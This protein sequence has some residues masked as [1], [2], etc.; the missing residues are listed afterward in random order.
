MW[1][2]GDFN[3]NLPH[4]L[5]VLDANETTDAI[6]YCSDSFDDVALGR[7]E[8]ALDNARLLA[9]AAQKST[10][11]HYLMSTRPG[12]IN[13]QQ[14][15]VLAEVGVVVIGGARQGLGAIDRVARWAQPVPPPR[16]ARA[17]GAALDAG[18]RKTIHEHDAKRLI[19]SW[20]VPV[21]RERLVG[22]LSEARAAAREIGYPVVLKAVS[23][24]VPH[25]TEHGLV[26]LGLADDAALGAAWPT[27]ETRVAALGA[28]AVAGYLVQEMVGDG[29]EVFAGVA[30]DPDFGLSIAFGFGGVEIELLRDFAMRALPLR[31][32]EAAAM[33]AETRGAARLGP[34]RGRP[35]AD[36][37]SL[38]AAIEA[39]ADFAVAHA[40]R[41]AEIDLNPIKVRAQGRGCVVIDALIVTVP[42]AR[43]VRR[44]R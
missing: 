35:A 16:P 19:A 8:R 3:T 34:V 28:V 10:K 20:G 39:L 17:S 41:I 29:I 43:E 37:A 13:R 14:V 25:K 7:A 11:P 26:A 33:I 15:A 23:D 6:A 44:A 5:A 12:V 40:D 42:S 27:L 9:A 38:V 30:R 18:A 36:T 1:G 32:G 22:T 21:T 2:N 4:A 31:Q 24:D